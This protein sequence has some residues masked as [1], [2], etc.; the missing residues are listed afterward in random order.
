MPRPRQRA[1]GHHRQGMPAVARTAAYVVD[2]AGRVCDQVSEATEQLRVE[3]T[4]PV[5]GTVQRRVQEVLGLAGATRRRSR[6]PEGRLDQALLSV[7]REGE[8]R[9]GD[10]HRVASPDLGELL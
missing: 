4:A 5:P 2:G 9:D 8:R 3:L 6:G 1:L 7:E 10:D